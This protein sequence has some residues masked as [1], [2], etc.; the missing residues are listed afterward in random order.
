M[1]IILV[2]LD[3]ALLRRGPQALPAS[4]S[5]AVGA[6][7][8]YAAVGLLAHERMA[9]EMDPVGPVLFDLFL[10]VTF[11]MALLYSRGVAN[12]A[13][14]TLAALGGTGTV[15]SLCALPVIPLLNPGAA[16]SAMVYLGVILWLGLMVWSLVV[17][18][19]ILRHALA[20]DFSM[21]L[22]CSM[23]YMVISIYLYGFLFG[24]AQ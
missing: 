24:P 12:R 18:A 16:G 23:I 1:R 20:L 14:Q 2:M 5:L 7:G 9:P 10:L 4:V 19:H 3:I 17:T 21:G 22:L 8:I 11:M 13:Y 6:L 15:L